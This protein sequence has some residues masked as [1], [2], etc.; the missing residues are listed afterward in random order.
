MGKF[1]LKIA[2]ISCFPRVF[3]WWRHSTCNL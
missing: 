3:W 2:K 1:S